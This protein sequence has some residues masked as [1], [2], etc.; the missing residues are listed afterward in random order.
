MESKVYFT[1]EGHPE[2]SLNEPRIR[3]VRRRVKY[4]FPSGITVS[5]AVIAP[6]AVVLFTRRNPDQSKQYTA[7]SI[8]QTSRTSRTSRKCRTVRLSHL[9]PGRKNLKSM[10]PCNRSCGTDLAVIAAYNR[11]REGNGALGG[12]FLGDDI[13][14]MTWHGTFPR[15]MLVTLRKGT[16]SVVLLAERGI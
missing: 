4:N 3:A 13:W 11:V 10:P 6:A 2:A 9:Q 12:D 8:T 1:C 14:N 15:A 7:E 5:W 16:V